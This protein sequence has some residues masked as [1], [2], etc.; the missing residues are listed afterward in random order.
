[1]LEL[2]YRVFIAV[3]EQASFARAAAELN[4]T[5]SAVSHIVAKLESEF[6]FALFL[7]RR[8]GVSLTSNGQR[9]LTYVRKIARE[10]NFLEKE[11]AQI[12]NLASGSVRIGVYYS[13]L[14]NWIAKLLPEL[15]EKYPGIEITVYQ[16]THAAVMSWL[17]KNTIDLAIHTFYNNLRVD[18]QPLY[19]DPMVCVAPLDFVPQNKTYVV[20]DDLRK[21]PLIGQR[22]CTDLEAAAYLQSN[23]INVDYHYRVEDDQTAIALASAGIGL[24]IMPELCC[25]QTICDVQVFPILPAIYRILG[26]SVYDRKMLDPARLST[27]RLSV[28]YPPF[29]TVSRL[30]R[31]PINSRRSVRYS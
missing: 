2:K 25:K 29:Q 23:H 4:L 30:R 12:R 14:V 20:A 10:H 19:Q 1:M 18:F 16:G 31:M 21:K 6:G 8:D 24:S 9:I 22:E 5:A 27:M 11:A 13:A 15:K 28:L 7:R 17:E 3:S 26:I